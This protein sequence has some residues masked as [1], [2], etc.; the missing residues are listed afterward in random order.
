MQALLGHANTKM[1]LDTY[2]NIGQEDKRI[3]INMI[4]E[5]SAVN[6]SVPN[7]SDDDKLQSK[8]WSNVK[9]FKGIETYKNELQHRL[10][11]V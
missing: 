4:E 1:L 7:S 8:K 11:N 5:N 2:M 3:S 9:R 6:L 10:E